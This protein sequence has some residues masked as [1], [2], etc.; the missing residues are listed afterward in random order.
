MNK[1]NNSTSL[2]ELAAMYNKLAPKS[3]QVKK[4]RDKE[5]AQR[6]IANFLDKQA[7]S[8]DAYFRKAAAGNMRRVPDEENEKILP[9]GDMTKR[10]SGV[11]TETEKAITLDLTVI[12]ST[13]AEPIIRLVGKRSSLAGKFL[14][15]VVASNPRRPGS[16]GWYSFE[17]LRDGMTYEQFIMSKGGAKHLAWDIDHG[18]VIALDK[19]RSSTDKLKKTN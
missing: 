13:G 9:S 8:A 11:I 3:Q 16:H 14:Y 17:A 12:E 18:Y 4:F 19:P 10:V 7:K 15:K 2:T 5:M 6:Y 1:N